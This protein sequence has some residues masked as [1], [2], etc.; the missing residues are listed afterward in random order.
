MAELVWMECLAH[1][2]K[3]KF[4]PEAVEIWKARGWKLCDPPPE[5]D[6]TVTVPAEAT[7]QT[8]PP[9]APAASSSPKSAR[10]RTSAEGSD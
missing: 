7:P 9:A 6:P 8:K 5:V 10:G 4:A 3:A 2:G 1:G